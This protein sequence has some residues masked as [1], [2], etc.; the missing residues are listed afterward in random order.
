INHFEIATLLSNLGINALIEKPLSFDTQS[1]YEL[2]A[3]FEEKNL[4]GGVGH[5]ERFN[6]AIRECKKRLQDLGHIYQ[7][8]T[9][10]QGPF[11]IRVSDVGVV[12]DLATHDIDIVEWLSSDK[13]EL[14]F[15]Q[16]LNRSGRNHEDL[17]VTTAR[18]NNGIV[19]N[20]LV[21]WLSPNKD[22]SIVITGENGAFDG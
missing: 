21:N 3:M 14:V 17:L 12:K 13:Y 7:I 11:Q 15:S 10:R 6:P 18:L 2:I 4:V 5:I 19:V 9:R 20:N 1:S 22:R 8:T 16:T